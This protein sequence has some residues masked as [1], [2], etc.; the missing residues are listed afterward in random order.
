MWDSLDDSYRMRGGKMRELLR[1]SFPHRLNADGTHDSICARC[2][3]T[4]ATVQHEGEL[5]RLESAHVCEPIN[6][7]RVRQWEAPHP[8]VIFQSHA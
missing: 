5:A 4:V 2:W 7:Y 8:R 3:T 1:P 6:L